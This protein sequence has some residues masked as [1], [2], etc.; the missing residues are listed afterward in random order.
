MKS[1]NLLLLAL[2]MEKDLSNVSK[3]LE[4]HMK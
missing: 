4:N 2:I 3:E 1:Q